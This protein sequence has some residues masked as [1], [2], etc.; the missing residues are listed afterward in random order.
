MP[1]TKI[2]KLSKNNFIPDRSCAD[3]REIVVNTIM[4]YAGRSGQFKT[5]LEFAGKLDHLSTDGFLRAISESM[6]VQVE[7]YR[8]DGKGR[9]RIT[10][11]R[12]MLRN[13]LNNVL[14]ER[15]LSQTRTRSS[16]KEPPLEFLSVLL[17]RNDDVVG[18]IALDWNDGDMLDLTLN[19]GG[20][21]QTKNDYLC[22]LLSWSC[23]SISRNLSN[24]FKEGKIDA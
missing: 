6:R 13:K 3:I 12:R 19:P 11:Y 17:D 15:I 21:P 8:D 10:F 7:D 4:S 24:Q 23:V 5:L 20:S 14:S 16:L 9:I 1:Q 18:I 22:D 2:N